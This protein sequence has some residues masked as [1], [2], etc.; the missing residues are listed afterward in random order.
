MPDITPPP[1]ANGP[2]AG[3]QRR[4]RRTLILLA[5]IAIAP[6]A[7]SYAAF[8]LFR[9][10]AQLNYGTLLPTAPAPVVDG[11]RQDG[12]AFRLADLRGRWVLVQTAEGGCAAGCERALYATR[13]ART[14][15][16]REQERITRVLLVPEGVALPES[17]LAQHPGL[18]VARVPPQA[19][20]VLPGPPATTILIDPLGNLVLQY[21]EDPDAKGI[22]KDLGRLLKASRIG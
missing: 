14:M 2:Q 12:S 10:D 3:V 9:H 20:A 16:G 22:A 7:A 21:G 1:V 19:S 8:Y 15:Q 18:V 17:L 5:A 6:I 13:Q 11:S 4:G